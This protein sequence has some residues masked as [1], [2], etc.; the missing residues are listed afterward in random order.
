MTI[1]KR[2]GREELYTPKAI[3]QAVSKA[4]KASKEEMTD[5]DKQKIVDFVEETIFEDSTKAAT[6]EDIQRLVENGLMHYNYYD[7]ARAYVEYRSYRDRERYRKMEITKTIKKKLDGKNNECSNANLDELSFGGRK[8]EGSSALTKQLALDYYISPKFAKNHRDNVVY[9]HDLSDYVVGDHNCL[10]IPF[11][12]LLSKGFSVKNSDCRPA[13]SISSALQLVAVLIQTQSLQQFG[14]VSATHLDFTAEKYIRK[15]FFKHY[16]AAYLKQTRD[17]QK[18]EVHNLIFEDYTDQFGM[19]H[20]KFEDYV[21]EHKEAFLKKFKLAEDDFFIGNKKLDKK[22]AAQALYDTTI[23]TKQACE[24]L[25]H[26][27]N[28]LLSRSGN[29][30][31]FSSINLG[32]STSPEGRLLTQAFF[33]AA[34]NGIGKFGRTSIFPCQIFQYDTGVNGKEGTPNYDLYLKAVSLTA[35]RLYPNYANSQWSVQKDGLFKDRSMKMSVI[36]TLPKEKQAKLMDILIRKPEIAEKIGVRIQDEKD[37]SKKFMPVFK[38]NPLEDF[39]TM[40]ALR[41]GE[42]LWVKWEDEKPALMTIKDFYERAKREQ[43]K[44]T[45]RDVKGRP[46]TEV[47]SVTYLPQDTTVYFETTSAGN[48]IKQLEERILKTGKV[49]EDFNYEDWCLENYKIEVLHIKDQGLDFYTHSVEEG[50]K[51]SFP[52]AETE[53][54]SKPTFKRPPFQFDITKKQHLIN[55]AHKSIFVLDKGRMWTKVNHVFKNP[56]ENTPLMKRVFYTDQEHFYCACMTTD[57]PV[58]LDRDGKFFTQATDLKVGDKVYGSDQKEY[59]IALTDYCT[60]QM[61]SYDIGT[62]TGTFIGSGLIMHNCRT[63]NGYDINFTPE[64][65]GELIDHLLETGELPD[66]YL[67]SAVQRDGRGN[68]VPAT[69][70]LPTVAMQAVKKAKGKDVVEVFMQLL[71]GYI[72][73]TR[74]ELLERYKW[75]CSQSVE[76]AAFMYENNT[77]KG[78]KPEEGI[79]SALK[80]GTLALGQLG[81]AECLYLLIGCDHTE[82][83]GMELAIQIETLFKKKCD[84]YKEQY[85]LNFG[86][87]YTPAESLCHTAMALFRKKYGLIENVSATKD[88]EGKLIPREHFTNSM[89]VPVEKDLSP[90]DKIDIE[91]KLTGFSSAGCIT[92]VELTDKTKWNKKAI[93]QIIDYAMAKDIPYFAI[94]VPVDTCLKCGYQGVIDGQECPKCGAKEYDEQPHSKPALTGF[95]ERLRRVT[96]YL[97]GS[98]KKAFNKGKQ[99]EVEHRTKHVDTFKD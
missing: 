3:I 39:S 7:T 82:E 18:D 66:N 54:P 23:E 94:N 92:Y 64:Y 1:I 26:N 17:F 8:G 4:A 11:D 72:E 88:A 80:H 43:D 42:T 25:I 13:G 33:S 79:Q 70:I 78:Y 31:P 14:G 35:R 46:Q 22:L 61:D 30:L 87:Y 40:G 48:F 99:Y 58:A 19:I 81:L 52:M 16:V 91:S 83:R 57:H 86:V 59:S 67:Y 60:E 9:I 69:I 62:A 44:S 65:F 50:V 21:R 12:D 74:D 68:I 51:C 38:A 36:D 10:S 53:L 37:G 96:G 56:L 98:Y 24:G 77:M 34:N 71:E 45:F 28:T 63:N 85:K 55:L 97:T 6:V 76:A 41:E 29:Q 84:G 49:S 32:K 2:D 5:A 15:S 47:V 27:L 75:V 93:Q 95:I 89:H 20:N 73:D 90:F